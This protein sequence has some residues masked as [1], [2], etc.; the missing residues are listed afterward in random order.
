MAQ[1]NPQPLKGY[2]STVGLSQRRLAKAMGVDVL[3]IWR[4]ANSLGYGSPEL[5]DRIS[6]H[7]GK[8]PF[9]LFDFLCEYCGGV[10]PTAGPTVEAE[11]PAEAVSA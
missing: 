2:L 4:L 6:K 7:L 9:E 11:A 8:S 3:T 1:H 5:R 10:K